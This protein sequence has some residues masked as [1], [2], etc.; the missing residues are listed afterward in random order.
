MRSRLYSHFEWNH[1]RTTIDFNNNNNDNNFQV[2][3]IQPI[4]HD[5][6]MFSH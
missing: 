4:E 1:E 6:T 3:N 2:E 5:Y